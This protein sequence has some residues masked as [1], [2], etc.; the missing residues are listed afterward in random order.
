MGVM[1]DETDYNV[2]MALLLVG[3][4]CFVANN[5]RERGL[6]YITASQAM[7]RRMGYLNSDTHL[8]GLS[9]LTF[10]ASGAKEP[11]VRSLW[12]FQANMVALNAQ[13]YHYIPLPRGGPTL[14][15][16]V[17]PS[18]YPPPAEQDFRSQEIHALLSKV[19]VNIAN[20]FALIKLRRQQRPGR[21][22]GSWSGEHVDSPPTKAS[23]E[24]EINQNLTGELIAKL[25]ALNSELDEKGGAFKVPPPFPSLLSPQTFLYSSFHSHLGC[26]HPLGKVIGCQPHSG[27]L[28]GPRTGGQGAEHGAD[29]SARDTVPRIRADHLHDAG[30]VSSGPHRASG[31]TELLA[32]GRALAA[33]DAFED[34]V[35]AIG[36]P[37][38]ILRGRTRDA[39]T[40]KSI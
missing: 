36:S 18:E 19:L 40:R 11:S 34:T 5:E 32:A 8:R 31:D 30:D 26:L 29:L 33:A 3:C 2:A 23:S 4:H 10:L 25:V 35:P 14:D 7:C 20:G 1:F 13:P 15:S 39:Q 38:G 9:F 37:L 27:C 22:E 17:E 28:L 24:P 12:R 16:I 21:E 6:Y